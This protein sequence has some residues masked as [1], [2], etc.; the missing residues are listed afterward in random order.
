MVA[1]TALVTGATGG[2]G[3]ILTTM[4][5]A[6]GRAVIAT[7]RDSKRG[8]ALEQ[9]GARFV[10][11]DLVQDDL[12]PLVAGA[13]CVFHLAALSSPWGER[14]DFVAA[15]LTATQ[16]LLDAAR[17]AKCGKFIFTSTPSV[18]TRARHQLGL[19]EESALPPRLVNH[20]AA[21]KL[22]AEQ[23]VLGASAPDFETVALRPRAI[24][25]PHD[26]VLLPRLLQAAER[27]FLPLPG[28]GRALLEP[29]DARDV[30]AALM[31]AEAQAAQ[32]NG[33]VFNVSGGEPVRLK[34]F[35][36]HVFQKLG[37]PVRLVPLPARLA[38]G[39]AR[40]AE[41]AARRGPVVAEPKLTRYAVMAMGWSQ[42]FDLTRARTV[43]QWEPAY[44]PFQAVDWAL[45][46]RAHA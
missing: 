32:A 34:A 36:R 46:E 14:A 17:A 37:K 9:E 4:L 35:V 23:A 16:R 28:Y 39:L 15:N 13:D 5:L 25:S 21:T 22:A 27:G 33:S 20:Y 10:G 31:A 18:Y 3:Q 30:A 11:A 40:L 24:I 45:E 43:L 38:L 6:Q 26:T 42:T 2:L 1:S 8:A 7:G 29:T 44:S 41:Q 12:A 19:T